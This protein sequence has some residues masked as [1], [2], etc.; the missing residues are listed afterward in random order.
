[1][2]VVVMFMVLWE[3]PVPADP[4][5]PITTDCTAS[6]SELGRTRSAAILYRVVALAACTEQG[7][8]AGNALFVLLFFKR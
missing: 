6:A 7:S 1:M 5:Q 2:P 3:C 8:N 4:P